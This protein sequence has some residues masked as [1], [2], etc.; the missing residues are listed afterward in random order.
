MTCAYSVYPLIDP[1][2][3]FA[4]KTFKDQVVIITGGSVGIGATAAL[5]YARAGAKVLVVAR[6]LENLEQAKKD[7][8]K[9]VPG[10]QVLVLSGDISDPEVGKRAVKSAVDAWGRVDVVLANQFITMAPVGS[11]F[12]KA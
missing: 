9:G 10:A 6:R 5:F 4:S 2:T 8:E 12:S 1:T 3:H 11:G 7:I